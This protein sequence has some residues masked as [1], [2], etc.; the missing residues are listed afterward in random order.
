MIK[1]VKVLSELAKLRNGNK[2]NQVIAKY[3]KH[4]KQNII[5]FFSLS[6]EP[7]THTELEKILDF[8]Y[9]TIKNA[10]RK[11]MKS[12]YA[13]NYIKKEKINNQNV[14]TNSIPVDVDV[15][16]FI[17]EVNRTIDMSKVEST[18]G[19]AKRLQNLNVQLPYEHGFPCVIH[20]L[21]QAG[22][23]GETFDELIESFG[24]NETLENLD[25]G[26]KKHGLSFLK[27]E[28]GRWRSSILKTMHSTKIVNDKKYYFLNQ[29]FDLDM[30]IF[31]EIPKGTYKLEEDM[32]GKT[33]RSTTQV[34]DKKTSLTVINDS[35]KSKRKVG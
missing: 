6:K 4:A 8:K 9:Y 19:F 13:L 22:K 10:L 1:H 15:I 3:Y 20:F 21:Q 2:Q 34:W 24:W 12:E 26:L 35:K 29:G 30:V 27:N 25:P 32:K 14:Y 17:K 23:K 11:I 5:W 7:V 33:A 28:F 16:Q 18:I 31:R